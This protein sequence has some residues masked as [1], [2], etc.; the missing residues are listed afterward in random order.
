M[1]GV[2][3]GLRGIHLLTSSRPR[4][5]FLC[6]PSEIQ[7]WMIRR[8]ESLLGFRR[9]PEKFGTQT[10]QGG[11]NSCEFQGVQLFFPRK[12]SGEKHGSFIRCLHLPCVGVTVQKKQTP[13]QNRLWLGSTDR[14][15]VCFSSPLTNN[16]HQAKKCRKTNG[17]AVAS[18]S[19]PTQLVSRPHNA[20]LP[21]AGDASAPVAA[22]PLRE[23][24]RTLGVGDVATPE[25]TA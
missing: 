4:D 15:R 20:E 17:E 13:F 7:M 5:D 21:G 2:R 10:K 16:V 12:H 9:P 14:T 25:P 19:V 18:E 24:P 22:P 8:S 1:C 11:S 3:W 6:G 23:K